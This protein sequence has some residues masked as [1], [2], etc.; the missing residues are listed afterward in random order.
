MD[1]LSAA[2][3]AF[4]VFSLAEIFTTLFVVLMFY[5]KCCA[6]NKKNTYQSKEFDMNN[7]ELLKKEGISNLK[8]KEVWSANEWDLLMGMLYIIP[9]ISIEICAMEIFACDNDTPIYDILFFFLQSTV[10]VFFHFTTVMIK[11]YFRRTKFKLYCCKPDAGMNVD[12]IREKCYIEYYD[13]EY[14]LFVDKENHNHFREWTILSY[15]F[16]L[17]PQTKLHLLSHLAKELYN[18]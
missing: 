7:A 4:G 8:L 13:D 1:V 5:Q 11:S 14:V 6:K 17:P 10:I 3:L 15:A 2:E 16:I 12:Y 18:K 9:I